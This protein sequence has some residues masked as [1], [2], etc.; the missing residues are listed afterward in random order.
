[1]TAGKNSERLLAKKFSPVLDKNF[2]S[3]KPSA[4]Y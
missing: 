4:S 3:E 1:L 2:N